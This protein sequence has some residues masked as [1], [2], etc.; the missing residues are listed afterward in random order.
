MQDLKITTVQADLVW[1]DKAANLLR[2]DGL[3]KGL[4]SDLVVLPEMFATGF[5]MDA[6]NNYSE[7]DG[8]EHDWMKKTAANINSVVC[9]SLIIKDGNNFFNRFLW[10]TPDGNTEFYDKR[11]LF[12]MADEH[13]SYAAGKQ[14]KIVQLKGWKLSL[15]VCYDLRFPVWSRNK[16]LAY[17]LVLYVANWPERR[18]HAWKSLLKARAIE[19]LAYCV[20]VNRVGLDG[21][22]I[23]YSGDSVVLD[24]LGQELTNIPAHKE[25]LESVI[26]NYQ[27]LIE[28]R[29]KFPAWKDADNFDIIH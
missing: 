2:F 27:N 5:S 1:Q 21:N 12:R 4:S 28:Y 18:A 9:G 25:K 8:P 13:H 10:V 26:L 23:S 19:N 29:E 16:N 22:E 24:Y 14:S 15:Q 20:G 17:D 6:A 3:L 11:H 7:M